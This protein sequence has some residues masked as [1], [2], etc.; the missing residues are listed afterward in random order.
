MVRNILLVVCSV[1]WWGCR[2]P[3]SLSGSPFRTWWYFL[4]VLVRRFFPTV[5]IYSLPY[6]FYPLKAQLRGLVSCIMFW[7]CLLLL[8]LSEPSAINS[9]L[10]YPFSLTLLASAVPVAQSTETE[11]L[12]CVGLIPHSLRR[13]QEGERSDHTA[14]QCTLVILLLLEQICWEWKWL[15]SGF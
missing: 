11:F 14:Q 6:D 3:F 2:E 10:P 7:G 5:L 13:K 15:F 8:H 12:S 9:L 4:L 1:I